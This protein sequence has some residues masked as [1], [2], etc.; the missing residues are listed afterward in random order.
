VSGVDL[1]DGRIRRER[2]GLRLAGA[3]VGVAERDDANLVEVDRSGIELEVD[4]VQLVASDADADPVER[5]GRVE[6]ESPLRLAAVDDRGRPQSG[7]DVARGQ[8]RAQQDH[9]EDRRVERHVVL[10]ALEA[11]VREDRSGRPRR[12]GVEHMAVDARPGRDR[13]RRERG[14]PVDVPALRVG[15]D[16]EGRR[17]GR[18]DVEQDGGFRDVVLLLLEGVHAAGLGPG[19][20]VFVVAQLD[21][22]GRGSLVHLAGGRR[23]VRCRHTR[24]EHGDD[25]GDQRRH[26]KCPCH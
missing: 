17:I 18:A 4:A 14:K 15:T 16:H 19:V 13:P 7:V 11:A 26:P 2:H 6:L 3:L 1:V 24:K 10:V 12:V 8:A 21:G 25:D 5:A 23:D 9:A 20:G 22:G